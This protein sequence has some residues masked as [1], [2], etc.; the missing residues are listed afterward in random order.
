MCPGTRTPLPARP[1]RAG[2]GSRTPGQLR[3]PPGTGYAHSRAWG[4]AR[5]PQGRR[6]TAAAPCTVSG[7]P[8]RILAP[9]RLAPASES[10]RVQ[11]LLDRR[12]S[13]KPRI[14]CTVG[15]EQWRRVRV[16]MAAG[17]GGRRY[18][19]VPSWDCG[20]DAPALPSSARL[21]PDNKADCQNV[22]CYALRVHPSSDLSNSSGLDGLRYNHTQ[23]RSCG[24]LPGGQEG[25]RGN[26]MR[27]PRRNGVGVD[28]GT[29]WMGVRSAMASVVS[30]SDLGIPI[31]LQ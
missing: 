17:S 30:G 6:H 31:P 28:S 26:G 4:T 24:G 23:P 21:P 10:P 12:S 16:N 9:A 27:R 7:Q 8:G 2:V 15:S 22:L 18:A 5:R 13:Q 1:A 3:A 11:A 14:Q 20:G 29:G 25:G 19:Q